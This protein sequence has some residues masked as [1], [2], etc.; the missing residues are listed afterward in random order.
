MSKRWMYSG[1]VLAGVSAA[2]VGWRIANAQTSG[3]AAAPPAP[4]GTGD[5]TVAFP[6]AASAASAG[7]G[8]A[9]VALPP[10]QP[11]PGAEG[12][13]TLVGPPG[14]G[15][16]ITVGPGGRAVMAGGGPQAGV[17]FVTPAGEGFDEAQRLL[18][19]ADGE[20][21]G[22]VQR[23]VGEYSNPDVDEATRGS[24]KQSIVGALEKQF[25]LRQQHREREIQQI[26]ERVKKLREA[27][28]KRAAAKEKIIERRLND[29]LTEAEGLG[30]GDAGPGPRGFNFGGGGFPAGG[31]PGSSPYGPAGGGGFGGSPY[32][33]GGGAAP[34]PIPTGGGGRGEAR[35]AR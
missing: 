26:E 32:G 4:E 23:L 5:E 24:L 12:T 3:P 17:M 34:A 9:P 16:T 7:A 11:G 13:I 21:E 19:Q 20:L 15:G 1:L 10:T 30:W 6:V 27:L 8:G 33:R 18:A 14:G 22:E 2:A 31:R 29:L 25:S 35:P 28:D